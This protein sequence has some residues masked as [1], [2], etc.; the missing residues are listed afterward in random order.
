M[1]VNLKLFIL[2]LFFKGN[3]FLIQKE[4]CH[5]KLSCEDCLKTM[6]CFW[7]ADPK[8]LHSKPRCL[9]AEFAPFKCLNDLITLGLTSDENFVTIKMNFLDRSKTFSIKI[10]NPNVYKTDIYF[11]T[12]ASYTMQRY[13]DAISDEMEI[14]QNNLSDNQTDAQYRY[15]FFVEKPNSP[16]SNYKN[17]KSGV[18]VFF[19]VKEN[20]TKVDFRQYIKA[21]QDELEAGF[22]AMVQVV[23]CNEI[24]GWRNKSSKFI[25]FASDK[26]QHLAGDGRFL[27]IFEPN[28]MQCHTNSSYIYTKSLEQDYP[29]VYQLKKM[30]QLTG[31]HV[32]FFVSNES[33]E[34]YKSLK[35][36]LPNSDIASFSSD[37]DITEIIT[38]TYKS[39]RTSLGISVESISSSNVTVFITATCQNV[40][41]INK[42][43]CI[44]IDDD[45]SFN[46]T[47]FNAG[48]F[49]DLVNVTLSTFGYFI[50]KLSVSIGFYDTCNCHKVMDSNCENG[51][52]DCGQ[53]KCINIVPCKVNCAE[54]MFCN[55]CTGQCNCLP[56]ILDNE[57]NLRCSGN[58]NCNCGAC[59]CYAQ[60]T[61]NNC[62]LKIESTDNC[63]ACLKKCPTP[64]KICKKCLQCD[65]C[66]T[67]IPCIMCHLN[68]DWL[69]SDKCKLCSFDIQQ[70]EDNNQDYSKGDYCS[71]E[72]ED[73]CFAYFKKPNSTDS[74]IQLHLD[75]KS[76]RNI[77]IIVFS[78]IGGIVVIGLVVLCS[79]KLCITIYDNEISKSN[80][81]NSPKW[82]MIQNPAYRQ[83]KKSKNPLYEAYMNE[84]NR[85]N[86]MYFSDKLINRKK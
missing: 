53:C 27:G 43:T 69:T 66:F 62:K 13:I 33:I 40:D 17:I 67:Y 7:C 84:N 38:Q 75:C 55:E 52:R 28:S 26:E 24:S 64:F 35:N 23:M 51:E 2:F 63:L 3:N 54:G 9:E 4:V 46:V 6:D 47:I 78:L 42:N 39:A 8:F 68:Q 71:V 44:Y 57:T 85:M 83:P 81:M 56:C 21:N 70:S 15:G 77:Y 72:T 30:L 86:K 48:E 16:F 79:W 76:D 14:I 22:E 20:I 45:L 74:L 5:L 31:I 11:L 60:Y 73:Q 32:I 50:K 34:F 49:D 12:D 82:E 19:P 59:E 10:I 18:D 25:I 1:N 41:P 80:T 36:Y 65:D 61:G 37:S 58:G 29:S